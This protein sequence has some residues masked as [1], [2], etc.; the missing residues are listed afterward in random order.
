[1]ILRQRT[2]EHPE[3]RE[4]FGGPI[5]GLIV[6]QRLAALLVD[7]LSE[8]VNVGPCQAKREAFVRDAV[9]S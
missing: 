4:H 8:L 5:P 2:E 6:A 7:K 9:R 1:L 3:E